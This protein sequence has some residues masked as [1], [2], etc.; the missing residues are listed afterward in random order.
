MFREMTAER[1]YLNQIPIGAQLGHLQYTLTEEKLRLFREA[2][3][4][5]EAAFPNIAAR[6]FLE[7]LSRKYGA[8]DAIGQR[9]TDYYFR[10]PILGRRL[11]VTGWVRDKLVQ[12]GNH[13][14]EV[15]TFAVDE[16]G[17][18]IIRSE[19]TFRFG[20]GRGAERQG[21]RPARTRQAAAEDYLPSVTKRVTEEVIEGF[22]AATRSIVTGKSDSPGSPSPV[23]IHT[24]AEL[25]SAM[26][27]AAAVAP[28]ELSLA[29]LHEL[30]DR[31]FGID[32]R[33]GGRLSVNFLR[34]VYAGDFLTARGLVLQ[35]EAVEDRVKWRLLVW[36]E[37]QRGEQAAA[38]EAQVTVPSPLT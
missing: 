34:P 10:P 27:L 1:S 31:N 2:V 4:Y 12:R 9:H 17:T 21:R 26:G 36:L 22:E 28:T 6:E 14:L 20:A 15:D 7:V 16:V 11:Q 25:A 5:P 3:G 23:N 32:F 30:L 35:K 19:H 37:N 24:G 13:L 8:P 18:E 38:G 33:Q 29:Y